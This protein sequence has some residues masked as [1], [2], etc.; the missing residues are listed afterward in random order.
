MHAKTRE[1]TSEAPPDLSRRTPRP[2]DDT[3]QRGN[4]ARPGRRS[5]DLV[6]QL[7]VHMQPRLQVEKVVI[8]RIIVFVV[9]LWGGS[10][11]RVEDECVKNFPSPP[12][13]L[14]AHEPCG[15]RCV[16]DRDPDQPRHDQ[17]LP[18][19]RSLSDEA[20]PRP[21]R[22]PACPRLVC[23]DVSRRSSPGAGR[24]RGRGWVFRACK[25]PRNPIV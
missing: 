7:R 8:R 20:R 24:I 13:T 23:H 11:A 16:D 14:R 21:K 9:Q 4:H 6:H 15:R 10:A 3:R 25:K 12:T 19:Q 5:P 2:G 18:R 22:S 17:V 1:D